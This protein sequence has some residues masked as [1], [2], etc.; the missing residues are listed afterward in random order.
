M[1]LLL[2][3]RGEVNDLV[4]VNGVT[5]ITGDLV[6]VV[7]QR[8]YI[9]LRSFL[10]EWWINVEYG[11][12]WL[13][14]VLGHKINKSS[15]DMIIQEQILLENGVEQITAFSS[16]YDNPSRV[17]SCSFRVRADTGQESSDIT[18]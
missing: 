5:P 4:F 8:L 11:V 3:R 12:P 9:R 15:V 14:R 7:T 18:I 6:D 17:Y 1:D 10:G 16:T 13:E 2:D